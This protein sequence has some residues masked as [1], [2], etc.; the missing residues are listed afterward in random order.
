MLQYLVILLDDTSVAYCHADNPLHERNLMP[1]DTLRKAI[2]WGM[3]ENLMIQY[4][5]PDYELPAEYAEVIESIDHLKIGRDVKIY[6][7][8]DT[9]FSSCRDEAVTRLKS[10]AAHVETPFCASPSENIVLRLTVSDFIA[11]AN[12]IADLLPIVTRLN[13]CLTDIETFTDE[14]IE[15]YKGALRTLNASLLTI[16]ATQKQPQV[17]ILTDRLQLTKMRNCEAG[18]GNITVAPNGKFYLCPAFY[19]DECMG[20]NDR[21]NHAKKTSCFSVGSLEEG[22]NIPNPQLLKLDHAPLCR[23]CDAYHCNRC[24]WL[25]Q[26]LTW[27]NN[28]PSRQQCILAHLERNAARELQQQLIALSARFEEEIKEINYLDPF[29]VRKEW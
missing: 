14:Q 3:C 13:I 27:D 4:V 16:Y 18:V 20:V 2:H 12:K 23:N 7:A 8:V 9:L 26:R 1:L 15:A 28:T 6:N 17:N 19:Y 10:D 25:N 11:Q 5:Y 21:M 24:I 22:L 29:E